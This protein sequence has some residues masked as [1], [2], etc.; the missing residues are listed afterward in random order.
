[1]VAS[2]AERPILVQSE[3]TLDRGRFIS[4]LADAVVDKDSKQS[5]GAI[6]GLTGS[7]GSGKTSILN[8]LDAEIRARYR[9]SYVVRFDPWLV[10]HAGDL[11]PQFFAEMIATLKQP[12]E[13]RAAAAAE[14]TKTLAQYAKIVSPVVAVFNPIAG[15]FTSVGSAAARALF[16]RK[17]PLPVIRRN[18]ISRLEQLNAPIVVLIDELDRVEDEEVRAIAQL[19]RAVADF[20]R[21]SYV[22]AYD[23]ERVIQ[24]LSAGSTETRGRAYLEKIVQLPISLPILMEE[25]RLRVLSDELKHTDPR[26]KSDFDQTQRYAEMALLLTSSIVSTPREVKRLVG[27]YRIIRSVVGEEVDWI[28]LL[29]FAAITSRLPKTLENIRRVPERCMINPVSRSENLRRVTEGSDA[30]SKRLSAVLDPGEG[31]PDIEKLLQRLFPPLSSK[32]SSKGEYSDAICERRCLYS[33]L[34]LGLLPGAVTR[35]DIASLLQSSEQNVVTA[36]RELSNRDAMD[37]FLERLDEVYFET[38]ADHLSFWLGASSYLRRSP[39]D[40]I[41]LIPVMRNVSDELASMMTRAVRRNERLVPVAA[42]VTMHLAK[43][44]DVSLV[45]DWVRIHQF[46]HGI[47]GIEKRDYTVWL[48]ESQTAELVEGCFAQWRSQHLS[49]TLIRSVW[50]LDA[51]YSMLNAGKWDEQC[52]NAFTHLLADVRMFDSIILMMY[53]GNRYTGKSAV[54]ELCDA[55]I[56]WR[57]VDE[58]LESRLVVAPIVVA[59]LEKS[60]SRDYND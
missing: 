59:A 57:K 1:M 20:P 56:F 51:V 36:F 11:I 47:G 53:A 19:V 54:Q 41:Q 7:W 50:D 44:G 30:A 45:P 27:S 26:L 37:G 9:N 42:N 24:A 22:L 58:R 3:D 15:V 4:G 8:L 39:N 23:S 34:R 32:Q 18:L 52:R 6:I 13:Q 2:R 33:V 29:G 25:E 31:T 17:E 35:A 14:L 28:D 49:G 60:K 43:A 12:N 46:G 5:T 40:D 55:D 10:S 48:N 38:P 16:S 21:V